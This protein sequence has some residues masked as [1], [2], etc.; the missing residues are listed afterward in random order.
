MFVSIKKRD[1]ICTV[2]IEQDCHSVEVNYYIKKAALMKMTK[3][4]E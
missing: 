3:G 1:T 2:L 4:Q